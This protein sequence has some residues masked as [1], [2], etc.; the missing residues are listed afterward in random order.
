MKRRAAPE[1]DI[2]SGFVF[3]YS[4]TDRRFDEVE[5]GPDGSGTDSAA[6]TADTY[7][8]D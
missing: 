5:G 7:A 6:N 1:L 3:A 4:V 8:Y 2:V